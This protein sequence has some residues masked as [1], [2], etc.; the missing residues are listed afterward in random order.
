MEYFF[1]I[2]FFFHI[3][4]CMDIFSKNL[5]LISVCIHPSLCSMPSWMYIFSLEPDMI[6]NISAMQ[7][8]VDNDFIVYISKIKMLNNRQQYRAEILQ[9]DFA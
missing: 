5:T 6:Q 8:S 4:I 3:K 1:G 9:C 2:C 7:N